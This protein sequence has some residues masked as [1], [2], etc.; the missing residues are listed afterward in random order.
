V[1]RT[2]LMDDEEGRRKETNNWEDYSACLDVTY[3]V[4]IYAGKTREH[5]WRDGSGIGRKGGRRREQE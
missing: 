2:R 5:D 1:H 4:V 3:W